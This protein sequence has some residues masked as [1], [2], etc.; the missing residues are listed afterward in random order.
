MGKDEG[1]HAYLC[2][3]LDLAII[4]LR[5]MLVCPISSHTSSVFALVLVDN[6]LTSHALPGLGPAKTLEIG[7]FVAR[8]EDWRMVVNT[9]DASETSSYS[10]MAMRYVFEASVRE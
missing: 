2:Q 4:S 6:E 9:V 10:L 1:E 7:E 8:V 3:Y 5:P